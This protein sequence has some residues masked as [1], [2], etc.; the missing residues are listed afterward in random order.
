MV[1]GEALHELLC[2][3]SGGFVVVEMQDAC[4]AAY[5]CPIIVPVSYRTCSHWA[6]SSQSDA[7]YQRTKGCSRRASGYAF[8]V[9]TSND[10]TSPGLKLAVSRLPTFILGPDLAVWRSTC[11][12]CA[13]LF[14]RSDQRRMVLVTDWVQR[15]RFLP[16]FNVQRGN[17]LQ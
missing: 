9:T 14:T 15:W 10:P 3:V 11:Q 5:P 1:S 17:P 2:L 4:K 12:R 7:V 13:F 8:C 16:T 6:N